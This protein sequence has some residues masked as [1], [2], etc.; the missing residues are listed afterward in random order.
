MLSIDNLA[1]EGSTLSSD[2]MWHFH[3]CVGNNAIMI[4]RDEMREGEARPER[5]LAA[6]GTRQVLPIG[7]IVIEA[8]ERFPAAAIQVSHLNFS[9][10]AK[11]ILRNSEAYRLDLCITSRLP[12]QMRFDRWTPHRFARPGRIFAVPPGETLAV[13]NN[14]GQESVIVA[15]L[16]TDYM[17]RL[18]E[19]SGKLNGDHL[20]KSI[21]ITSHSIEHLMLRLREEA[22]SPGFASDIMIEGLALQLSVELQRHY[23]DALSLAPVGGLA[24]WCLRRIDDRLKSSDKPASLMELAS[25]CKMSVRHLSRG[26]RASR[27]QS[28]GHYVTQHRIE[29]AKEMLARDPSIKSVAS[30]M[31]FSSTAALSSAFRKATGLAPSEFRQLVS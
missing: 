16:F 17:M 7:S 3:S 14:I 5:S 27:G 22:R 13:W 8:D 26:F 21:N 10:Q 23:G 11:H 25:L 28:I 19:E 31:G 9:Q 18:L 20:D 12:A 30:Q 29:R 2:N 4:E 15:Y 6:T 1:S 24:P